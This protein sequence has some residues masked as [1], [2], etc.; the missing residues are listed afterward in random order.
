MSSTKLP[1]VSSFFNRATPGRVVGARIQGAESKFHFMKQCGEEHS[2]DPIFS[3]SLSEC[4][5]ER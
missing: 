3:G 4:D 2:G 1:G 5:R